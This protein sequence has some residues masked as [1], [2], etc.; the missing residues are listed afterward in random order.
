MS[1]QNT[2]IQE[3]PYDKD[4]II[5]GLKNNVKYFNTCFKDML[6]VNN[7]H[8]KD[9]VNSWIEIARC[10]PEV[11]EKL[12]WKYY[13]KHTQSVRVNS[14][15]FGFKSIPYEIEIKKTDKKGKEYTIKGYAHH[16][17][18][19]DE[20]NYKMFVKPPLYYRERSKDGYILY[21]NKEPQ[22]YYMNVSVDKKSFDIDI[23]KLLD[24]NVDD[25][26]SKYRYI[27]LDIFKLK[28]NIKELDL[29]DTIDDF[30]MD[31]AFHHIELLHK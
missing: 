2:N 11:A 19:L 9:L 6:E 10:N 3:I 17:N 14:I 31:T 30:D 8:K 29:Y 26:L 23:E 16:N 25:L 1:V 20:I 22:E 13:E 24:T 28:S 12:I 18:N 4:I 15:I 21:K 5:G 27:Y 7:K